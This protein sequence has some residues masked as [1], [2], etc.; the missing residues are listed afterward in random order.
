[1]RPPTVPE[2]SDVAAGFLAIRGQIGCGEESGHAEEDR[3]E[4]VLIFSE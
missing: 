3:F 2:I 4:V 1:M